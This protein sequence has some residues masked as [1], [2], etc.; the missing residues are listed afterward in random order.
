MKPIKRDAQIILLL[1]FIM[2]LIP[3]ILII[4]ITPVNTDY[5]E[6]ARPYLEMDPIKLYSR[7]HFRRYCKIPYCFR[8]DTHRE[9]LY[10]YNCCKDFYLCGYYYKGSIMYTLQYKERFMYLI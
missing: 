9:F 5:M 2:F 6:F 7:K 10:Y 4:C 1:L 8:N 3:F